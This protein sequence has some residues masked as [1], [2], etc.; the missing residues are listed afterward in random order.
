MIKKYVITFAL[1]VTTATLFAQTT[2][3]ECFKRAKENY[4]LTQ[5]RGL[6]EKSREYSI[7]NANKAYIPQ[8]SLSAQATYQS[9]TTTISIPTIGTITSLPKEQYKVAA[10]VNQVIWGGGAIKAQKGNIEAQAETQQKQL[11]SDLY[12]LNDRVINI[13]F[14]ILLLDEQIAQN[15]LFTA[16]LQ[17]NYTDISNYIKAGTAT[18]ADLDLVSVNIL[19][20]KQQLIA[21]TKS[22]AAYL[23]MLSA[24]VGEN[25]TEIVK[26]AVTPSLTE[27][28]S[29]PELALFDAQKELAESR[30][31]IIASQ[32][33]PTIGAFVQ[34]AYG[35]PGLNMLESSASPYAI[36]GVKLSWNIAGFYTKGKERKK[37][38]ID[39][40]MIETSRQT[41]IFNTKLNLISTNQEMER[42]EEQMKNDDEII[43]LRTAIKKAAQGKVANG[44]MSV[45]DFMRE[46]TQANSAL[47]TK[48]SH[49][50]ELLMNVYSHKYQTGL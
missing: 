27:A 5:Q 42:L 33:T 6:I 20:N 36:G 49:E 28:I 23:A 37:V 7:S 15:A 45:N 13:F 11:E 26:P 8:A 25:V 9:E 46:V 47:V 14:G 34:G 50:V 3:E 18:R 29:R 1:V 19:D 40:N 48:R 16:E 38:D 4:P 24:L 43:A 39:K 35:Q 44:T 30:R 12:T 32:S 10:E 2:I 21:L 17:R 22:R 31:K 41:F